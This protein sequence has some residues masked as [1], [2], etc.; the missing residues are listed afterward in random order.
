MSGVGRRNMFR[1]EYRRRRRRRKRKKRRKTENKNRNKDEDEDEDEEEKEKEKEKENGENQTLSIIKYLVDL[2]TS[3]DSSVDFGRLI[4]WPPRTLLVTGYRLQISQTLAH[5]RK[6]DYYCY[7]YYYGAAL[8]LLLLCSGF[9]QKQASDERF[10]YKPN[11]IKP[12]MPPTALHCL[13][14]DGSART[15][16]TSCWNEIK[17]RECFIGNFFGIIMIQGAVEVFIT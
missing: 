13:Q 11:Q 4:R 10:G 12:D 6:D 2:Q 16:G 1:R 7:Y 8:L 9:V 15:K 5:P 3:S 14:P 17:G